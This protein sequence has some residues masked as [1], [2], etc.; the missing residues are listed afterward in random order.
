MTGMSHERDEETVKV[1]EEKT[2]LKSQHHS[3]SSKIDKTTAEQFTLDG[4]V[5]EYLAE[6]TERSKQQLKMNTVRNMERE[7]SLSGDTTTFEGIC[8]RMTKSV[9]T[10]ALSTMKVKVVAPPE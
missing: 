7:K 5:S 6:L 9:T 4:D 1:N 10:L 2:D 8:E 3:V